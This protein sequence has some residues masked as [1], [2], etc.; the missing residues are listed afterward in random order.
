MLLGC[1]SLPNSFLDDFSGIFKDRKVLPHSVFLNSWF[2][3]E[4][5]NIQIRLTATRMKTQWPF[6]YTCTGN[7]FFFQTEFFKIHTKA[8][9]NNLIKVYCSL[10]T[11]RSA[12][13]LNELHDFKFLQ[14][15]KIKLIFCQRSTRKLWNQIKSLQ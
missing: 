15:I 12:L 2:K 1:T 9:C 10:S 14:E 4:L 3:K 6:A 13:P 11:L 8:C 7:L 5:N